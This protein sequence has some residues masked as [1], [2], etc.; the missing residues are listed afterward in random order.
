MA[1]WAQRE[2]VVARPLTID[3]MGERGRLVERADED[4]ILLV[5]QER[6]NRKYALLDGVLMERTIEPRWHLTT[7][8]EGN[9]DRVAVRM[10]DGDA[11]IA[12]PTEPIC[13]EYPLSRHTEVDE[14]AMRIAGRTEDSHRRSTVFSTTASAVLTLNSDV[15]NWRRLACVWGGL[16]GAAAARMPDA[17]LRVFVE[18]Q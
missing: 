16:V 18:M 13:F 6:I 9:G 17:A 1:H 12:K 4:S 14:I 10:A 3:Q 5:V 11:S 15:A 7:Y 2:R 8:Q